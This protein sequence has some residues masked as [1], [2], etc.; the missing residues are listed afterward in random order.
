M[1]SRRRQGRRRRQRR[2]ARV[3]A[4]AAA[5]PPVGQRA[6]RSGVA[7][8]APFKGTIFLRADQVDGVAEKIR[9]GFGKVVANAQTGRARGLAPL[10]FRH[11]EVWGKGDVLIRRGVD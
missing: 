8:R 1:R 9:R 5:D 6:A 11:D 4:G 10:R 3:E 7:R 2:R